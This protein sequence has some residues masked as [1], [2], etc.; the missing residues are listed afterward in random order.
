MS[1]KKENLKN[2]SLVE[3]A[4]KEMNKKRKPQTIENLYKKIFKEYGIEESGENIS[5]FEI[6]FM[7]SG[8]FIYCGEDDKGHKLWN[9]KNREKSDLLDKEGGHLEDIYNEDDDEVT[10]NELKDENLYDVE[11]SKEIVEE[12]DEEEDNP[13]E[14]EDDIANE[15]NSSSFGDE[16]EEIQSTYEIDEGEDEEEDSYDDED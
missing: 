11:S 3:I 10:K 15:L 5:Q 4:L 14:E 16:S 7:L 6:D 8:Q 12:T 1:D 13:K 2:D 9:L